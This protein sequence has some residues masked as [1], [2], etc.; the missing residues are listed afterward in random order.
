MAQLTTFP[1][2]RRVTRPF[3]GRRI[4][5]FRTGKLWRQSRPRW[6]L[7]LSKAPLAALRK[8][9]L[10]RTLLAVFG[11]PLLLY[12][13]REVR[14]DVLIIDPITVPKEWSESGMTPEAMAALVGDKM[15]QIETSTQTI[16]RKDQPT[17]VQ[18]SAPSIELPGTR[19]DLKALVDI[20]RTVFGIYPRHVAGVVVLAPDPSSELE[21]DATKRTAKATIF[22]VEGR[23]MSA[24]VSVDVPAD[25]VSGL[26]QTV[27][28]A[29]LGQVNPY[30]LA[31]YDK[32]HRQ[33][34]AAIDLAMAIRRN[35]STGAHYR[36]AATN[37]IGN[38]LSDEGKN[39]EAIAKYQEA[40]A[41][42]PKLVIAWTSWG[43]VLDDEKRYDEAIAKFQ[44]AIEIDRNYVV[45]WYNWGT[46]LTHENRY[47]EALTKYQKAVI[48]DPNYADA[49]NGLGNT[50]Y[51]EKKYGE[52]I[53]K[54][55]KATEVD[56]DDAHAWNNWGLALCQEKRYYEADGKLENAV[57]I[58]PNFTDAW[59][60]LGI[61]L[62]REQRYY[63]ATAMF[64]RATE[65]DPGYAVAWNNWGLAL[66][67]I[68][69]AARAEKKFARARALGYPRKLPGG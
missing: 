28:E 18:D 36:A 17:M 6:Q 46:T 62:Y 35:P 43:S 1:A 57:G 10:S 23:K 22:V 31:V 68:G 8:F 16:M 21:G 64:Q 69:Q 56:P 52:A 58:D 66:E 51:A 39:D 27:A 32:N 63:E 26:V 47:D 44:K 14:R 12:I 50:L 19:F 13:W 11:V 49:W 15:R 24:A 41:I 2:R 25:D 61:A 60:A 45:P 30:V 55:Q 29:A 33:Y 34:G 37:L 5:Q 59:N 9:T 53:A 7:V 4:A 42:D 3:S 54:Y 20:T 65:L 38:V 40:L 67:Q 48:I